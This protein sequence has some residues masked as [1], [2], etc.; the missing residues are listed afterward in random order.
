MESGIA[1]NFTCYSE[2]FGSW[3]SVNKSSDDLNLSA[4]QLREIRVFG[5]KYMSIF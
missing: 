2:I 3:M 1:K 4:L 5:G